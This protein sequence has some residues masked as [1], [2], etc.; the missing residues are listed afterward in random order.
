MSLKI[1]I[2]VTILLYG[3][4]VFVFQNNLKN[5]AFNDH[6]T[7]YNL[8]SLFIDEYNFAFNNINVLLIFIDTVKNLR[9]GTLLT[10]Q[11][12]WYGNWYI[13]L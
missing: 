4:P 1:K 11:L 3:I 8:C 9:N 10:L 7:T 5:I 2:N 12:L 6:V 13:K